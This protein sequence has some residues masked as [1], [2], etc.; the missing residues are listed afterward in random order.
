VD[1]EVVSFLWK[2]VP[3]T[4]QS[5][6]T[7][8]KRA[9]ILVAAIEVFHDFGFDNAS[10]DHIAEVAAVSKRTVY[11]HFESKEKL[12]V[13]MVEQ[14]KESAQ[15]AVLISYDP[16]RALKVQ[17]EEFCRSVIDFHS[18]EESRRLARIVVSKFLTDPASAQ[19]LF[20][21]AKIFETALLDWMNAVQ[22]AGQLKTFP[23][24]IVARQLLAMLET[25]CVW[26][27]LL[28]GASPPTKQQRNQVA[29]EAT[30]MFLR[31]YEKS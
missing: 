28:R 2:R 31:C 11:N 7:D 30:A 29:A 3:M 16:D 25:F 23:A 19:E 12:F 24:A 8:R 9:A 5:R 27:Q 26:P 1:D 21:N 10:M 17:V 20:G 18:R 6:L 22:A 14:L 4:T 15:A 13:A